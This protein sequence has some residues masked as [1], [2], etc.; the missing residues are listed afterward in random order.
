MEDF[1]L[2]EL[3]KHK[4]KLEQIAIKMHNTD[5]I[6]AAH[7]EAYYALQQQVHDMIENFERCLEGKCAKEILV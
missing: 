2:E 7:L 4:S 1:S 6:D 5:D 3:R